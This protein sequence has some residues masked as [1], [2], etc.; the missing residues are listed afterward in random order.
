[1]G[2]G[3][4]FHHVGLDLEFDRALLLLRI[5]KLGAVTAHRVGALEGWQAHGLRRLHEVEL[6]LEFML[7]KVLER[8]T[9][10][11][12]A[13]DIFQRQRHHLLLHYT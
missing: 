5:V 3:G 9:E 4:D 10:L 11:L 1:M 6:Y 12:E 8:N 2:A 7:T 13:S